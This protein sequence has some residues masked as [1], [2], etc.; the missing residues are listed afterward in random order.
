MRLIVNKL[1]K[2]VNIAFLQSSERGTEVFRLDE[3]YQINQTQYGDSKRKIQTVVRPPYQ[4]DSSRHTCVI[5]VH[6]VDSEISIAALIETVVRRRITLPT[7]LADTLHLLHGKYVSMSALFDVIVVGAGVEG[8][9]TAYQLARRGKKCLLLEQVSL[10]G[11]P[12]YNSPFM[13]HEEQ[14]AIV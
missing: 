12:Q 4:R 2:N 5:Q 8:S 1:R 7:L 9:A 10:T 11:K 6:W 13:V 3:Y 14:I